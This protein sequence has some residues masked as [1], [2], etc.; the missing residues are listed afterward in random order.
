MREFN[1]AV[2]AEKDLYVNRDG[3]DLAFFCVDAGIIRI[4]GML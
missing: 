1:F 3:Y 4:Q 2:K